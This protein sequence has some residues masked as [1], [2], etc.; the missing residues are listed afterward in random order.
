MGTPAES[1][2][3]RGAERAGEAGDGAGP[4]PHGRVWG[5]CPLGRGAAPGALRAGRDGG[6]EWGH[7]HDNTLAITQ[8]QLGTPNGICVAELPVNPLRLHDRGVPLPGGPERSQG[9]LRHAPS[10]QQS[11][12]KGIGSAACRGQG[13][14]YRRLPGCERA[15]GCG[16]GSGLCPRFPPAPAPPPGCVPGAA[17]QDPQRGHRD[18]ALAPP[19]PARPRSGGGGRAVPGA[20][21]GA[22]AAARSRSRPRGSA[23]AGAPGGAGGSVPSPREKLN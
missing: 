23:A 3:C 18:S 12:G 10:G 11:V 1:G 16:Q 21:A 7:C 14:G 20:R 5:P 13:A 17:W 22:G 19:L 15:L 6:G 9:K 4:S 2:S 8:P